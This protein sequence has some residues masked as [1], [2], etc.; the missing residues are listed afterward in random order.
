MPADA[1]PQVPGSETPEKDNF[2]ETALK[3]SGKSEEEAR[4]TGAID[5]ADE[6]VEEL[7]AAKYR[8]EGSPCHQAVWGDTFPLELFAPNE[9][10]TQPACDKV[11]E[12]SVDLIRNMHA[13]GTAYDANGKM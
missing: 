8:T 4:K 1:T 12:K 5:R 10:P 3:L 11:M 13:A 2:V 6:Q 9:S 7:F